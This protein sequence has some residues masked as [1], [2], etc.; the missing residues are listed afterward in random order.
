MP[1]RSSHRRGTMHLP[2]YSR[3]FAYAALFCCATASAKGLASGS[4]ILASVRPEISTPTTYNIHHALTVKAIPSGT[5]RVRVWFWIPQ[6][7][8][9]QRVLDL[10]VAQAPD[11]Y[12]IVRNE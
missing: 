7:D 2:F 11:G 9:Y 1:Q 3:T 8:P 10:T 4:W 6:E 5:K 12:Q